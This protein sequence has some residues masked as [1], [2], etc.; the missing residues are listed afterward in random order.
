MSVFTYRVCRHPGARVIWSVQFGL[1]LVD[2]CY[3]DI[4][5]SMWERAWQLSMKAGVKP[6]PI[7]FNHRPFLAS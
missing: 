3:C 7:G 4:C 5:S 6:S 1:Y 2:C